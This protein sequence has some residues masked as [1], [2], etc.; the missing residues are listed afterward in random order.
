MLPQGDPLPTTHP[1]QLLSLDTGPSMTTLVTNST[2][3]LTPTNHHSNSVVWLGQSNQ[4]KCLMS[5]L[6]N[7]NMAIKE[8]LKRVQGYQME[9]CGLWCHGL[10]VFKKCLVSIKAAFTSASGVSIDQAPVM[11]WFT[12]PGLYKQLP[13]R[14][15][16]SHLIK[17]TF[18]FI[19][20]YKDMQEK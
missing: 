6:Y 19:C 11:W 15:K 14:W 1:N 17:N 3:P 12:H 13:R 20:E 8:R 18:D 7:A 10:L 16:Q 9:G 4:L 5:V 2:L